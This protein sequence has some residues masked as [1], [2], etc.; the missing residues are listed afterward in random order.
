VTLAET[1]SLF[2]EALAGEAPVEGRRLEACFAGT[3]GFPAAARVAVYAG[4]YLGRLAEALRETFPLSAR[5][6]GEER[7]AA[8]AGDYLARHPSEHHDIGQVGRLVPAFLREHPAP[9][10]PDLADLAALEWA[11]HRVFFAPPSARVGPE[12]FAGLA[13]E[14]LERT[15]LLLSPALALLRLEHAVAPLWRRLEDGLAPPPPEPGPAA[16]AVWRD[17]FQVLHRSLPS[18]EAE[19]LEGA[20]SGEALDR[21]C[22]GFAGRPD[23]AGAA[24]AALSGWLAEGWIAGLAGAAEPGGGATGRAPM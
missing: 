4:M 19:A 9:E 16:V 22:A 14:D 8:L 13:P 12:A 10:R 23:P 21:V 7:F 24:H 15:R 18:D 1:Q 3:P 6:L 17:G 5:F 11:R 2:Q 20:A